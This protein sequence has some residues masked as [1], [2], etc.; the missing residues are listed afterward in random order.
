[1]PGFFLAQEASRFSGIDRVQSVG[2]K[3]LTNMI[4]IY[5]S[6]NLQKKNHPERLGAQGVV[7]DLKQSS[8]FKQ[9]YEGGKKC[10]DC[11]GDIELSLNGEFRTRDW[12]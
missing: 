5:Q 2:K 9:L 12:F 11:S 8:N 1:M 6:L 3:I 10:Y 7:S 4:F